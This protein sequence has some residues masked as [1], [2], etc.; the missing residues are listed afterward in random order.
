[1]NNRA[2]TTASVQDTCSSES[3]SRHESSNRALLSKL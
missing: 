3:L 2:L 1:M